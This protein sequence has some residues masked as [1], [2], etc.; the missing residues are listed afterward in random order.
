MVNMKL[1]GSSIMVV[2]GTTYPDLSVETK[3]KINLLLHYHARLLL[4]CC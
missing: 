4:Q 3:N 2:H 1:A